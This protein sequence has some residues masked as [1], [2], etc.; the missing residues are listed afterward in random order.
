MDGHK[1]LPAGWKDSTHRYEM[2]FGLIVRGPHPN[3]P[4]A[5]LM[6]LAGRGAIGTEAA[7]RAVTEDQTLAKIRDRLRPLEIDL[8]D[9]RQAFWIVV[10]MAREQ[11]SGKTHPETQEI[12]QADRFSGA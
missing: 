9:H 6:V 1:W 12:C 10:R 3:D 2:D 8:N 5:L 7:C 4:G 11:V